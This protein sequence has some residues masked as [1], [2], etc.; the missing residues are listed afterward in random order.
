MVKSKSA[1]A[2]ADGATT[3]RY[4]DT[5]YPVAEFVRR[6]PNLSIGREGGPFGSMTEDSRRRILGDNYWQEGSVVAAF[7]VRPT[8]AICVWGK[9]KE[10]SAYGQ[11]VVFA[12]FHGANP[13]DD[14]APKFPSSCDATPFPQDARYWGASVVGVPGCLKFNRKP[15]ALTL[16]GIHECYVRLMRQPRGTYQG[17]LRFIHCAPYKGDKE[18]VQFIAQQFGGRKKSMLTES[19][20]QIVKELLKE[21]YLANAD[22][23]LQPTFRAT[24]PTSI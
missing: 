19:E 6:N 12:N 4:G 13:F 9:Q 21:G 23:V 3:H 18:L 22:G 11:Y 24:L 17:S 10:I 15:T 2:V 5:D 7:F 1:L 14:K 20:E 8:D 16:Q